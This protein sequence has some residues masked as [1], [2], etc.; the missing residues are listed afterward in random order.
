MADSESVAPKRRRSQKVAVLP[1]EPELPFAPEVEKAA[2]VQ[3]VAAPVE[4][5]FENATTQIKLKRRRTTPRRKAAGDV[6]PI[7]AAVARPP[8]QPIL[9]VEAPRI[10]AAP[11][12]RPKSEAAPAPV[13]EGAPNAASIKPIAVPPAKKPWPLASRLALT[14][15][16]A[17]LGGAGGH[18]AAATFAPPQHHVDSACVPDAPAKL[19][20]AET[21]K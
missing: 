6:P 18:F 21:P 10:E 8:P 4:P 13:V 3:A 19:A 2:E 11:S 1:I 5:N 17:F 15:F 7:L 14:A 20:R 12:A 16:A 9:E